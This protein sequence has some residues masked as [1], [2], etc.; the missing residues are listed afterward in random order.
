[1][2]SLTTFFMCCLLFVL[3]FL[4]LF[5]FYSPQPPRQMPPTL[6]LDQMKVT[7]VKGLKVKSQGA[8][9]R[10]GPPGGDNQPIGIPE[11]TSLQ[12][13]PI[14]GRGGGVTHTGRG[15]IHLL[16]ASGRS[17]EQVNSRSDFLSAV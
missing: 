14:S 8:G 5:S 7:P 2:S 3:Q 13:P 9:N 6:I 17:I 12:N 16:A 4:S 15:F 10:W 1:M 11:I